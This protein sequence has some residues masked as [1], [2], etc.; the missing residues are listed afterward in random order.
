MLL[1]LLPE[2]R[3]Q[4]LT[5]LAFYALQRVIQDPGLTEYALRRETGLPGYEVSRACKF[6]VSSELVEI[7]RLEED[8]RVRVLK[9]T[10]RGGQVRDK[11]LS[12]AAK[13]LQAGWTSSEDERRLSETLTSYSG[14]DRKLF[15]RFQL[16]FFDSEEP[17]AGVG[18]SATQGRP[19]R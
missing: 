15:G 8:R 12:T 10:K 6:L 14:G 7:S 9:A 16:S 3:R 4:G 19:N 5:F 13:R 18:P 2:L 17:E 11:V 1:L